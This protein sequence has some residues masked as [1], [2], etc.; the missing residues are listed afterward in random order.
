MSRQNLPSSL[1]QTDQERLREMVVTSEAE[2]YRH[3]P[4]Q[5]RTQLM[6]FLKKIGIQEH[7]VLLLGM[8]I[9]DQKPDILSIKKLAEL[10][11]Q[12]RG[13]VL[14]ITMLEAQKKQPKAAP[15]KAAV[16]PNPKRVL[17]PTE[18]MER[19]DALGI[20]FF[21]TIMHWENFYEESPFARAVNKAT[22]KQKYEL[23]IP[24][25]SVEAMEA[26]EQAFRA[27]KI[28]RIMIDD[29]RIPDGKTLKIYDPKVL[30]R[31]QQTHKFRH[32]SEAEDFINRTTQIS[33]EVR[34]VGYSSDGKVFAP[35]ER[36]KCFLEQKPAGAFETTMGLGTYIRLT[37][38]LEQKDP[39]YLPS[40]TTY[41][42]VGS[43]RLTDRTVQL[44]NITSTNKALTIGPDPQDT[45]MRHI[46]EIGPE[47]TELDD[48]FTAPIVIVAPG[49]PKDTGTNALELYYKGDTLP[50]P[51]DNETDDDIPF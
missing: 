4:E 18:L 35:R 36:Q 30:K 44:N 23:T 42:V 31:F 8:L 9:G 5:T 16:L 50:A 46:V 40:L 12:I 49:K 7:R 41:T 22:G 13:E 17:A 27:K 43:G 15:A 19:F 26:F 38:F 33:P 37:K 24:P 1:D 10:V 20:D 25:V 28:D 2:S 45:R 51:S 39:D 48:K 6:G 32:R 34:V 29:G 47:I 3:M 11:D 14:S 21:E